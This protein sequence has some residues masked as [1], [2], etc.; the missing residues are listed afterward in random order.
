MTRNHRHLPTTIQE[1]LDEVRLDG[2]QEGLEEGQRIEKRRGEEGR[3]KSE[4]KLIGGGMQVRKDKLTRRKTADGHGEE[5]CLSMAVHARALFRNAAF[6][7]EAGV[8]TAEMITRTDESTQ[9]AQRTDE[10][11]VQTNTSPERRCAALR[12]EPPDDERPDSPKIEQT[13]TTTNV[14]T[15]DVPNAKRMAV[16]SHSSHQQSSPAPK[17]SPRGVETPPSMKNG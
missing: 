14:R 17:T 12:M 10:L 5:L 11:A 4:E 8:Q 3:M 15:Q 7:D 2:W 6:F 16:Q 13:A 9:V 1:L